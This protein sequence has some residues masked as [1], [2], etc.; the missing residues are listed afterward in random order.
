MQWGGPNWNRQVT[1]G[2]ACVFFIEVSK[3]NPQPGPVWVRST[4]YANHRLVSKRCQWQL[5]G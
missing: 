2:V 3:L 1:C 5:A 4:N